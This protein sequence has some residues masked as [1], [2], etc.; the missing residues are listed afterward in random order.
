M[1]DTELVS[2]YAFMNSS[3]CH[4]VCGLDIYLNFLSSEGLGSRKHMHM[5]FNERK[6]DFT[7]DALAPFHNYNAIILEEQKSN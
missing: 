4:L 7:G 2:T 3:S 5:A 6:A 1:L